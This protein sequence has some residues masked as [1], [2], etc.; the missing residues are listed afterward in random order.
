VFV[1]TVP[2]TGTAATIVRKI[3]R[4]A[5]YR[6][7]GNYEK[8]GVQ[9]V[10][11]KVM[12]KLY[13]QCGLQVIDSRRSVPARFQGINSWTQGVGEQLVADDLLLVGQAK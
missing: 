7:V 10:T 1:A 5:G 3:L 12:R 8:V 11:E 13:A 6:H 2:N 9:W 4:R